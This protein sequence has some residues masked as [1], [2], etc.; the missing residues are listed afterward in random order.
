MKERIFDG[1]SDESELERLR[2]VE[3]RNFYRN[4]LGDG[5]E[6]LKRMDFNTEY[7]E[8]SVEPHISDILY[9]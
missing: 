2:I 1:T 9:G 4:A 8:P 3:E 5:T 6:A 7:N